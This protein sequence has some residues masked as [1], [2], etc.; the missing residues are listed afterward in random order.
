MQQ[1]AKKKC[2]AGNS[3]ETEQKVWKLLLCLEL[4][5]SLQIFCD[6]EAALPV[7]NWC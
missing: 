6:S 2:L 1:V 4:N 5:F 7:P 3:G